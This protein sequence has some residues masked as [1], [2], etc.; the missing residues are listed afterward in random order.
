MAVYM[1]VAI[2]ISVY[3]KWHARYYGLYKDIL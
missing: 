2:I 1:Q 3:I